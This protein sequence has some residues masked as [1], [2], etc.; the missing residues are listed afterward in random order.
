MINKIKN[1]P[2]PK[3]IKY[4]ILLVVAILL[5]VYVILSLTYKYKGTEHIIPRSLNPVLINLFD[6]I[7]I[8]WYAIFVI[9]G[10]ALLSVYGYYRYLKPALLDSDTVLTGVTLGII[11]GVLGGR[12]YYVIFEHDFID[13]SQN[14]FKVFIQIINPQSGGLAIHGALYGA[15]IMIVIYTRVKHF[16]LLETIE[17]VLPVFMLAQVLGRWG[18]FFNQEAYG[19]LVL[20]Y[21][22]GPLTDS[23]LIAQREALRHLLVPNF[24]INNMY[25]TKYVD[26][27]G[28][29]HPTFFYEGC[30]N[31]IIAIIYIELRKYCKKIYIGD[32]I[33]VYLTGYGI[34]RL[35][36]EILR[37]DPLTFQLFGM[38]FKIAIV[39]S[40]LFIIAGIALFILRRVFKYHLIPC[41]EF[42][43][44]KGS[45]WKEG[46]TKGG[47]KIG[48]EETKK[49]VSKYLRKE[50]DPD[51]LIIMDCDGT[52]LNTFKLIEKATMQVFDEL[53][54]DYKYQMEEIH[55]F[56][57]PLVDESFSK[58]VAEEDLPK[59]IK[60]YRELC[61]LYQEEYVK[62]YPGIKEMLEKLKQRGYKT[63]ILSNKIS[64]AIIEGLEVAKI[65]HL[66]DEIYGAEKLAEVKPSP[67]G[68]YQV[69]EGNYLDKA[70]IVGDSLFDIQAGNNAKE[71]F[72]KI[73]TV[74]VTW[75][76]T[77]KEEFIQ[78]QADY[79]IGT[80]NELI[81]VVDEYEKL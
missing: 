49:E 41:N 21:T 28:Y 64:S 29:Y 58:Y 26:I 7:E 60:R 59:V 46:Y 32:G 67:A 61:S 18:N 16:K 9:G 38:T 50:K 68:I 8:R 30:A 75:C 3:L 42:L 33:A 72:P 77:T 74:G 79:I 44:G 15:V 69:I 25:I 40:I 20:N 65:D 53:I 48:E 56:F 35:F 36:I 19:P 27:I 23:E 6:R 12:I 24:V 39:T 54:P 47:K 76:R 11:C 80:P 51:K 62:A 43:Y 52:I 45:L 22:S 55:A 17:I 78:Y 14:F 66:I 2:K 4:S 71:G 37:Q 73:R 57:G 81:G 63:I 10:A 1:L 70:L 13:F 34:V 5:I 31:F